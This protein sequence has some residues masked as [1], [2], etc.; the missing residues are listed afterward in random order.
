MHC[1]AQAADTTEVGPS[2]VDMHSAVER[3]HILPPHGMPI[4]I[5]RQRGT[6]L[7]ICKGAYML[8][9]ADRRADDQK[10]PLY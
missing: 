3:Q 7:Q 8:I 10:G 2:S 4:Q 9:A 6:R 5:Q 1:I